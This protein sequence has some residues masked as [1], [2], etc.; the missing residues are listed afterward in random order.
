MALMTRPDLLLLDEPAAGL[1]V[2]GREQLL[3]SVDE[4]RDRQPGLATV[5]VTHHL[6]ELPASTTHALLLRG[7]QI[8]AAGAVAEVL[9]SEFASA[10]FDYPI[11]ISRHAGRWA[12]VSA[13]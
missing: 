4:L 9:T 3:A 12:A 10:C 7:G 5:L 2:A 6:E 1:D 11:E 8:L 13:R